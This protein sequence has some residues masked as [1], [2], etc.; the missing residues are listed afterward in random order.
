VKKNERDEMLQKLQEANVARVQ[1][2]SLEVHKTLLKYE[3]KIICD[4]RILGGK[5][6]E[7]FWIVPLRPG[8]APPRL[9]VP[10]EESKNGN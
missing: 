1:E 9:L 6:Q 10:P 7:K 4:V 8:E 5:I 3:C 2:C